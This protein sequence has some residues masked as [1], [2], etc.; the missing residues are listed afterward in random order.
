M[1]DLEAYERRFRRRGLPLFIEG[2]SAREDVWTRA[3]PLLALVF[4]GE[5]LGAIQFDWPILVNVAAAL[6]GLAILLGAFGLLNLARGRRF[7]SL[8]KDVG[9]AELAAFV[10]VPAALPL[11]FGGQA[12]SAAITVAANLLLL[13]LVYA[14]IAYGLLAIVLW[15]ARRFFDQLGAALSVISRAVPLLLVF[16]L[17]LFINTEMWQVFSEMPDAFLVLVGG[18]F[19][20]VGSVFVIVRLPREVDDLEREVGDGPPL[21]RRERANVGLVMFVSQSLQI[22]VVAVAIGAFFVLFGA[23]AIGTVVREAWEVDDGT[24]ILTFTLFGERIQITEALVRVSGGIAAFAGLYYAIAVLTDTTYRQ[25]FL[26]ELTDDM[27]ATFTERAE[28][29]ELRGA[30]EA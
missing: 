30:A 9:Y 14:V 19:V 15:A 11:I 28:Y 23:L 3:A 4:I 26:E 22:V 29:R 10:L 16:S 17:V 7:W 8:P 13:A 24:S 25:E 21:D 18:L 27:R 20:A 2:R 5:M 1:G 12:G 6:G